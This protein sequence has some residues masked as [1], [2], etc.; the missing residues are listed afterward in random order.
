MGQ[1]G[2]TTN[3]YCVPLKS[4]EDVL[5]L[6]IDDQCP[7]LWIYYTV[8]GILQ[9]RILEWVAFPSPGDLLNPGIEPYE[10]TKNH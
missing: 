8:D 7:H 3:R 4:D 5:E 9:A 6:D 1:W 10:Y 2:M